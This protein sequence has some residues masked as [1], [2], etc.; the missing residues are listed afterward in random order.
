MVALFRAATYAVLLAG[1]GVFADI[2]YKGSRTVF[3]AEAPFINTTFL[4][5]SPESLHVF[6][7]EGRR[8]EM[9]DREFRAFREREPGAADVRAESFVYSAGGIWPCIAGTLLLV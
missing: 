6:E 3:Q 5:S 2:L 7:W 9:G 8:R 1:G 4:F